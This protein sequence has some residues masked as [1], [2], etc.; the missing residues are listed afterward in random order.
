MAR[1]QNVAGVAAIHYSLRDIDSSAS[2]IGLF[3]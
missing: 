2:N 3:V 1:E